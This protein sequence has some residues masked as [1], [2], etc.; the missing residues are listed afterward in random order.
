MSDKTEPPTHKKLQDARKKGQVAKSKE[1]SSAALIAASFGVLFAFMPHFVGEIQRMILVPSRFYDAEFELAANAVLSEVLL[2]SLLV[3]APILAIVVVVAIVSNMAQVGMLFTS[4]P[5]KPKLSN[6]NPGHGIKKM[7]GMK[8]LVEFLKSAFKIAFLALLLFIVIRAGLQDLVKVPHCGVTCIPTVLGSLLFQVMI[9]TVAA[10]VI[11]AAADFVYQK[12]HFMKEQRM[13]KE[14]VKKEYKEME[15]DPHIK[16]KRKQFHQELL[17]SDTDQ[18]VRSSKVVVTNPT[19]IA[20]ALDYR[21]GETPLPLITAMGK[22]LQ[23]KRIVKIA[24]EAGIPI[25][26]NVPV[27]RGLVENGRLNQ[28]IPADM[29]E[30]VAEVLI[31]VRELEEERKG[32]L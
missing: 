16:G 2:T 17:Q 21:E 8:N 29:I 13:S 23:A 4:E 31:W 7:F 12:A 32:G 14:E 20:V 28:Y 10:F 6:L 1:V 15:G 22:G 5:L 3:I 9:Y 18:A 26:Q 24:Q 27:A 11:I 25:M 30:A 19:H